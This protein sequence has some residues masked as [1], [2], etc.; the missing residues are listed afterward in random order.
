MSNFAHAWYRTTAD[1]L[2]VGGPGVL[3]RVILLVSTTGGDV[4][5]YDG[6]DASSGRLIATLKGTANVSL[7]VDFG[8]LQLDR[9][10]FIDIGSNVSEVTAVFDPVER[11]LTGPEV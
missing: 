7:P 1:Q 3:H 5:I 11:I 4:T 6:L 2:A 8:G 10:L 9:G